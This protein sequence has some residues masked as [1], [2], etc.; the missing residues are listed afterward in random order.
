MKAL[1]FV[2]FLSG[3]QPGGF[4]VLFDEYDNCVKKQSVLREWL[5]DVIEMKAEY[6]ASACAKLESVVQ[7]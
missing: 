4:T 5:Y 2:F 1:L 3:G 7:S 6:V